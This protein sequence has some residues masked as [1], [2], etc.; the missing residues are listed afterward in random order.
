MLVFQRPQEF[1]GV[2]ELCEVNR[3]TVVRIAC[4]NEGNVRYAAKRP[5]KALQ[6][7]RVEFSCRTFHVFYD[8]H[9]PCI[10]DLKNR[11]KTP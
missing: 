8:E 1:D 7:P 3:R 11:H 4:E 5:E 6:V 10:Q 2:T 9:E